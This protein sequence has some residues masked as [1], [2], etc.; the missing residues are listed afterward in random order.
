MTLNDAWCTLRGCRLNIISQ[1][2]E[3]TPQA[4]HYSWLMRF[5]AV[6]QLW[7]PNKTSL[8]AHWFTLSAVTFAIL[9]SLFS[10]DRMLRTAHQEPTPQPAAVA[11]NSISSKVKHA[12]PSPVLWK[13]SLQGWVW[14][15]M[16]FFISDTAL[17]VL[18]VACRFETYPFLLCAVMCPVIPSP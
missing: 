7:V 8:Q 2:I 18:P 17:S 6:F 1:M 12:P 15:D 9:C 16:F 3:P 13:T 10:P 14:G 11:S 5:A 4:P